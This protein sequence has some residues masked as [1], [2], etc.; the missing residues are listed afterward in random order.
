MTSNLTIG[1]IMLDVEGLTLTQHEKEKINHPNTGAVILFSRNYQNPEQVTD[2]INSIRSARNGNILI[3]VDQEGGRVQRF[4]QG[5]TRLPP[6]SNYA[7]A[8]EIAQQ[9]GWL[10]AAE[11]LAVGV[12][13]SFA[14]VLDMASA[15][16]HPHNQA[17]GSFIEVDGVSQP[18]PV[19]RF[20][21][22]TPEVSAPPATPGLHSEAILKD[23]QIAP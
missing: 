7:H 9:A 3:A 21:R 22:S 19:P 12:D 8:P 10:M 4:Q 14:P 5:F 15:P 18:A 11:L 17:R 2:L 16:Q 13:F 1:P 20:S 6:A 23:W